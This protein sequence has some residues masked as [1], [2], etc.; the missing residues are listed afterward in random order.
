MSEVGD[1]LGYAWA[2]DAVNLKPALDSVLSAKAAEAI[3]SMTADVAANM[4]GATSGAD[5]SA[6][7]PVVMDATESFN[8]ELTTEHFEGTPD[9]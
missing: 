6:V 9:A 5:V 7:E 4:F 3:S 2:K 8:N 1:I